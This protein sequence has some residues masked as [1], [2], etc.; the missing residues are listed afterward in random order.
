MNAIN[1]RIESYKAGTFEEMENHH[2]GYPEDFP[3]VKNLLPADEG[4]TALAYKNTEKL[5]ENSWSDGEIDYV[6]FIDDYH[7]IIL[8]PILLN[9]SA[10]YKSR[11]FYPFDRGLVR[12]SNNH[13]KRG[14]FV[15]CQGSYIFKHK[16]IASFPAKFGIGMTR[17]NLIIAGVHEGKFLAFRNHI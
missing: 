2:S 7:A 12:F 6:Y 15:F 5:S 16:I 9:R 17:S 14:F 4:N 13:K 3:D 1:I 10:P 8:E 11:L